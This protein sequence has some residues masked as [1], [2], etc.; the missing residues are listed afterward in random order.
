MKQKVTKANREPCQPSEVEKPGKRLEGERGSIT[1]ATRVGE[2]ESEP[3]LPSSN[4]ASSLMETLPSWVNSTLEQFKQADLMACNAVASSPLVRQP[5]KRSA[6]AS[7]K[8]LLFAADGNHLQRPT[9]FKMQVSD[10]CVPTLNWHMDDITLCKS[11]PH[12]RSWRVKDSK[13]RKSTAPAL[14]LTGWGLTN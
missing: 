2:L 12:C 11:H 10:C 9:A 8:Q 1:R 4:S 3:L 6:Q 13:D 14:R 5:S 7:S